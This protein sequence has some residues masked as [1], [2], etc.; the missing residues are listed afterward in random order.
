MVSRIALALIITL[1]TAFA[2]VLVEE[3]TEPMDGGQAEMTRIRL[4]NDRV[5]VESSQGGEANVFIYRGDIQTMYMINP[6]NRTYREMSKQDLEKMMGQ[7]NDQMSQMQKMMEEKLQGMPP[8]Q[9]AMIE[10][11]MKQKM[12]GMGGPAAA[13]AQQARTVYTKVASGETVN[14]WT[15]DKYEGQRNGQKEMEVWTTGW[16]EFGI[17]Q[18]DFQ[19]FQDLAEFFRGL[20]PQIGDEMFQVGSAEAEQ[21]QGFAGVPVRRL[22]Y[23]NGNPYRRSEVTQVTRQDFE[24]ALFEP[25]Q[26]YRKEAMPTMPGA[27]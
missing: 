6:G 3:R 15:T 19:V 8:Q 5:R 1:P 13:P 20:A 26:D 14:Q 25:P 21:E 7:V 11:M 22:F 18:A 16:Q 17:T 2:G 12:G 24:A 9:R 23:R 27:R 4:E 10:Q